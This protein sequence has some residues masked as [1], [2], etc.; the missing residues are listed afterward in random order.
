MTLVGTMGPVVSTGAAA[1]EPL[2]T[3]APAVINSDITRL[4]ER[5]GELLLLL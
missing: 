3:N 4:A 2:A 1:A 5:M